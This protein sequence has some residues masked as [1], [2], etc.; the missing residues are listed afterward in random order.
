MRN[1]VHA[2]DKDVPGE[3]KAKIQE[4]EE[5]KASAAHALE[6]EEPYA[7][8]EATLQSELG[9][10][11]EKARHLWF[12]QRR[13]KRK[14]EDEMG[15]LATRF[16]DIHIEKLRHRRLLQSRLRDEENRLKELHGEEERMQRELEENRN[17][18]DILRNES[19]RIEQRRAE[20]MA[21]FCD[22]PERQRDKER[23]KEAVEIIR[24]SGRED[25]IRVI[26]PKS[27]EDSY[28]RM[29]DWIDIVMY[30][31]QDRTDEE[32]ARAIWGNALFR[33]FMGDGP[34][35]NLFRS[36]AF[37]GAY[38]SDDQ[39]S[40]SM[41]ELLKERAEFLKSL[42]AQARAKVIIPRIFDEATEEEREKAEHYYN[43]AP[44]EWRTIPEVRNKVEAVA[45]EWGKKRRTGRFIVGFYDLGIA[46]GPITG[47]LRVIPSVYPYGP[48]EWM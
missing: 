35:H 7:A 30:Q 10:L 36:L 46:P 38:F 21:R 22:T 18:Q 13:K 27:W 31:Y 19:K 47:T 24:V 1:L 9:H 41:R 44:K 43:P 48:A 42:F 28:Q 11:E 40:R 26:E 2:L 6:G 8:E 29:R 39:A 20:F 3:I 32:A 23:F 37:L 25:I 5:A 12:F 45:A 4:R 17:T 34:I 16:H 15:G 14:T 33:G